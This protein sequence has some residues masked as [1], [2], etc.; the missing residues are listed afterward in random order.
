MDCNCFTYFFWYSEPSK[1][2]M[3]DHIV[4]LS[5]YPNSWENKIKKKFQNLIFF[6]PTLLVTNDQ[7]E[8]YLYDTLK[9]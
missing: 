6:V 3:T 8:E 2:S 7:C 1:A 5:H 9:L 4:S